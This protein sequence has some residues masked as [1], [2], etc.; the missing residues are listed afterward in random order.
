MQ[1]K[2]KVSPLR[3]GTFPVT[4]A[5]VVADEAVVA[6]VVEAAVVADEG[7]AADVV[8]ATLLLGKPRMAVPV[9]EAEAAVVAA[10]A[11]VVVAEAVVAVAAAVA[12]AAEA[13]VVVGAEAAAALPQASSSTTPVNHPRSVERCRE[14]DPAWSNVS[15]SHM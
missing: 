11:D 6:D 10:A 8:E 15:G 4:V 1:V 7:V 12:V 5:D 14:G 9:V 3:L 2:T 13:V